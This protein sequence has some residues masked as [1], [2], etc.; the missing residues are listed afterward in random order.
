M[1]EGSLTN[2]TSERRSSDKMKQQ[3]VDATNIHEKVLK[4][5]F[6]CKEIPTEELAAKLLHLC[7]KFLVSII[8][9]NQDIKLRLIP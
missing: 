9:N 5:I 6:N 3:V 2:F 7:Y 4:Y 1:K 8:E